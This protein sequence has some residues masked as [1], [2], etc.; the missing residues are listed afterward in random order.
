MSENK[1]NIGGVAYIAVMCR[2]GGC[3]GCVFS[4]FDS[5]CVAAPPCAKEQRKDAMDVI[6][7]EKQQ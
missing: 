7:V 3:D 5:R 4:Y 6:F 1:F 2:A